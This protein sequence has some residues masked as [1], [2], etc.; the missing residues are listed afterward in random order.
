MTIKKAAEIFQIDEKIIRKSINDGM[1]SKRKVGNNIEIP[2][3][4]TFIPVKNE[5]Q[6]FLYQILRYKN[7]PHYPISRELCPDNT[8]LVVLFEYLYQKGYITEIKFTDSIRDL[9]HTVM[10]TD[11]A[12]ELI[13][14]KRKIEQL[15]VVNLSPIIINPTLKIGLNVV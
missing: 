6:G 9:F 13:F 12:T 3:E 11:K 2:D 7:N 4:T 1:I 10:L 8:S 5:I 15:G 14:S